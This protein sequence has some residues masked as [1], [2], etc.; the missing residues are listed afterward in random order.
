MTVKITFITF[1]PLPSFLFLLAGF[2]PSHVQRTPE[3]PL[4]RRLLRGL[5]QNDIFS[6]GEE[7]PNKGQKGKQG[8]NKGGFDMTYRD[9]T[10]SFER[11]DNPL[12]RFPALLTPLEVMDI[13]GVGKN[14]VYRLLNSGE[15]PAIRIGRSWK[16]TENA[17]TDFINTT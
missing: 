9:S 13:L 3:K 8:D 11:E 7:K 12:E 6:F 5:P 10:Y 1:I 2:W 15:L 14:T 17:L 16:I 4:D